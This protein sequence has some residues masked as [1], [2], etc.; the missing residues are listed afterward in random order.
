MTSQAAADL[1]DALAEVEELLVADPTPRGGVSPI[2][3]LSRVIGRACVVLLT[4][5]LERFVAASNAEAIAWINSVGPGG[6]LLPVLLRLR[7]TRRVID[8]LRGTNWDNRG[9]QLAELTA[10]DGWLWTVGQTGHLEHDR[11]LDWMSSPEPANLRS[12]Y[13]I[14]GIQDIF[15]SITRKGRTRSDLWLRLQELVDKRH[16]IAHGDAAAEATPADVRAYRAAVR[17]FCGRADATFA[18][19]IGHVLGQPAPW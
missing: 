11:L 5:H 4:S 7:H 2:P 8:D 6:E 17:V 14:W 15:S 12:Y 1:V 10:S 16:A 13:R 18:R 9:Q 19:R 3:P